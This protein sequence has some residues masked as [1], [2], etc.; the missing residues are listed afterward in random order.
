MPHYSSHLE[1]FLYNEYRVYLD[2]AERSEDNRDKYIRLYVTLMTGLT[3]F[4]STK[5]FCNLDL[6]VRVS[7][8]LPIVFFTMFV[9]SLV[10]YFVLIGGRIGFIKCIKRINL[11]RG[12]LCEISCISNGRLR[13]ILLPTTT[14]RA[15]YC[16][17]TSTTLLILY[18]VSAIM[19]FSA[20]FFIFNISS[21]LKELYMVFILASIFWVLFILIIFCWLG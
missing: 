5:Y 18:V 10:T 3:T 2:L 7:H 6:L 14:D 4:I 16:K 20:S 21:C 15:T 17:P 9:L 1:N 12:H 19:A 13:A 11:I 8:A